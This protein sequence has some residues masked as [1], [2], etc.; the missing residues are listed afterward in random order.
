MP[1]TSRSLKHILF[2]L[3][4][5]A[6]ALS[7]FNCGDGLENAGR[8]GDKFSNIPESDFPTVLTGSPFNDYSEKV[9]VDS[10]NNVLITGLT[11]GNLDDDEYFGGHG[12]AVLLKY[13]PAG[14]KLWQKEF[15]SGYGREICIDKSDDSVYVSFSSMYAFEGITHEGMAYSPD[16]FLFKFDSSG[17]KIW[18][19]TVATNNDDS[20]EALG[21][22]P[23]G[24][25]YL[26][27]H[28]RGDLA[29]SGVLGDYDFY[30]RKFSKDGALIKTVQFGTDNTDIATGIDFDKAGNV[31]LTGRTLGNFASSPVGMYDLALVKFDADLNEVWRLQKGTEKNDKPNGIAIDNDD[32]IFLTGTTYAALGE[33]GSGLGYDIFL[34]KYDTEGNEK[35]IKQLDVDGT[36]EALDIA[37]DSAGKVYITG[38][39]TEAFGGNESAGGTDSFMI[40]YDNAGDIDLLIQF[41]SPLD[42]K[43]SGL[44]IDGYDDVLMT[45][46]SNGNFDGLEGNGGSDMFILKYDN[47]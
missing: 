7:H 3:F 17:E 20:G 5:T 26:A 9:A 29:G 30:I 33:G 14:A 32:N 25:L 47:P 28:T 15:S 38:L 41:G 46:Y 11:Y 45:G 40:R 22:S 12:H 34:A 21:V 27:G 1:I 13:S 16:I 23:S 24:D 39:I 35:F 18:S 8:L 4:L 42:D 2:F 19:T 10:K 37:V 6:F 43:A 44:A 31:Y 36:E